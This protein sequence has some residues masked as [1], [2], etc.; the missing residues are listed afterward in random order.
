MEERTAH[1]RLESVENAITVLINE[2][3]MYGEI[4]L[5]F[6]EEVLI[7]DPG[8]FHRSWDM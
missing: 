1:Y 3:T 8:I 2:F 7:E 5:E 6:S 4:V